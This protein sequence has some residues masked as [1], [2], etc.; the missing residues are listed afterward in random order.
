MDE[1]SALLSQ[2][3]LLFDGS[4]GVLLQGKKLT[5]DDFRGERFKEHHKDVHNNPDLL[6]ITRPEIVRETHDAYLA[7][8]SDI[9]E[10]NTFTATTISQA[11]YDLDAQ[12]VWEMNVE[13]AR[14]AKEAATAFRALDNRPQIGRAHV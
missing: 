13:G 11:D 4:Y 8:G 3:I 9:I 1:L 12:V 14:I 7:A 5:E 10:T 6:N 2:R